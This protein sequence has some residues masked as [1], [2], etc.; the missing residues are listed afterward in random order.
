MEKG[1]AEEEE[2][3][4]CGKI[5]VNGALAPQGWCWTVHGSRPDVLSPKS[6]IGTRKLPKHPTQDLKTTTQLMNRDKKWH[7]DPKTT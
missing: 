4:L 2:A 3:M 7:R 6:C 5:R 1:A